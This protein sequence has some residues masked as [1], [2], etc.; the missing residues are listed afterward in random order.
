M[1]IVGPCSAESE[2]QILEV[3]QSLSRLQIV[4]FFRAGIW[5]PR[6][7]PNDFE[8]V[9]EKGLQWL[10]QAKAET[11]LKVGTEV[12]NAHHVELV[13]KH[14]LDMVW[15][16]A[17]TAA[18]PFSVSEIAQAL[19]GCD[20][21]VFIKNPIHPDLHLWIGAIERLLSVGIS[22]IAAVH[23]GFS[24]FHIS[25]NRN[26]PFW[27]LVFDLKRHFPALPILTDASHICGK[28]ALIPAFC[29]KAI[30]LEM[31]GLML[32][33]HPNPSIAKT[34]EKQQLTP[35]EFENLWKNLVFR[36]HPAT[37]NIHN[38]LD[39]WRNEIDVLDVELMEI[40]AR[41]LQTVQKIGDFKKQH[42]ITILQMNRWKE[43]VESRLL[44][45]EQKGIHRDF[46]LE[47]LQSIHQESIRI[48]TEIFEKED[49][50][51]KK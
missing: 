36:H 19:Q 18:N 22:K 33:V 13:L 5:K 37:E 48:Q 41:R 24:S 45:G 29:Q 43:L 1:M 32:E 15:I 49:T 25:E 50:D 16:G 4:D 10:Q 2:T 44:M 26:E 27:E 30:D 14:Q 51:S 8:G 20:I 39:Q 12:A 21:P 28:T 47:I 3:A 46:L 35:E 34:D 40:L 23:R 9:G 31:N 17:R 11:G 38:P 7:Q 6:T 42:N